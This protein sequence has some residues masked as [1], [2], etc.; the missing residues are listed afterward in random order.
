MHKV[1]SNK[2]SFLKASH[3]SMLDFIF[4]FFIWSVFVKHLFLFHLHVSDTS[5]LTAL[6]AQPSWVLLKKGA[7]S[8]D[9]AAA[10]APHSL[11]S[12]T[13]FVNNVTA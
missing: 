4:F 6:S 10:R 1:K 9:I 7:S 2:S 13:F 11:V 8:K 12:S 5:Q 3:L